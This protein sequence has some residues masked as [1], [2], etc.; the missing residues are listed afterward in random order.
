VSHVEPA[1]P[2]TFAA[3][4]LVLMVAVPRF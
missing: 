2:W 3:L 4:Y 1:I